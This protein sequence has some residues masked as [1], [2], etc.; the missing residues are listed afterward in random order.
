[1]DP[2]ISKLVKRTEKESKYVKIYLFSME[3]S[4]WSHPISW[5]KKKRKDKQII[6]NLLLSLRLLKQNQKLQ[7]KNLTQL[8]SL[9]HLMYHS[10]F[11]N[12]FN[13]QLSIHLL[14][15]IQWRKKFLQQI[16]WIT[17]LPNRIHLN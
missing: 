3:N 7:R 13:Q 10:L 15:T 11:K 1:M 9:P 16:Q 12:Q 17:Q 5:D 14:S 4:V 2:D 6:M 8:L